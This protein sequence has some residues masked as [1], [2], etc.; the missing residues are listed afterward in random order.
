[1]RDMKV[2]S[3]SRKKIDDPRILVIFSRLKKKTKKK[4]QIHLGYDLFL[5]VRSSFRFSFSEYTGTY[6]NALGTVAL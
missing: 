5:S 4:K 3:F 6:K 2:A 1:M